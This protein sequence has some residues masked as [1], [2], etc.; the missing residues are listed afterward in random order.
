VTSFFWLHER[1]VEKKVFA[2]EEELSSVLS[3]LMSEIQP[4][5]ILRAFAG[6]NRRPRLCLLMEGEYVE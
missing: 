4:N 1:T 6:W 5:M 2:E 3:E